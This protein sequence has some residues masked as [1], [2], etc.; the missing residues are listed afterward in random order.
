MRMGPVLVVLKLFDCYHLDLILGAQEDCSLTADELSNYPHCK[1]KV[2]VNDNMFVQIFYFSLTVMCFVNAS[3]LL[4]AFR[5]F[6]I[7]G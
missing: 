7:I 4:H 6:N 1:G 2:E 3:D 5:H